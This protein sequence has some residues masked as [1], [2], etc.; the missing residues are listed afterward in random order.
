MCNQLGTQALPRDLH[1]LHQYAQDLQAGL[2]LWGEVQENMELASTED[3]LQ[4]VT[5]VRKLVSRD[6]A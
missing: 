5:P 3:E 6:Q 4:Q 1:L 2:N